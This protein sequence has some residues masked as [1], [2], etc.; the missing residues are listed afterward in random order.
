MERR[1]RLC[2]NSCANWFLLVPM[3][4][5][6]IIAITDWAVDTTGLINMSGT[7]C[8]QKAQSVNDT[9]S[10]RS[11]TRSCWWM[12]DQICTDPVWPPTPEC[13]VLQTLLQLTCVWN[14]NQLY[15]LQYN[16]PSYLYIRMKMKKTSNHYITHWTVNVCICTQS[17][18]QLTGEFE[19]IMRRTPLCSFVFSNF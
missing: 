12:V 15:P 4:E 3:L 18:V 9:S 5:S 2:C 19:A 14:A 13:I 6:T 11:G 8:G 7:C 10:G 17:Y 1:Q 16:S